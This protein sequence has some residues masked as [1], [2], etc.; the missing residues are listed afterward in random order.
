M[1]PTFLLG[2][3]IE[4]KNTRPHDVHKTQKALKK[5]LLISPRQGAVK[6]PNPCLPALTGTLSIYDST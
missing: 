2:H 6:F 5:Y 3:M 1:F 4:P